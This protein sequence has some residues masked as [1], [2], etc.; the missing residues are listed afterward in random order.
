MDILPL[1]KVLATL[2]NK[3]EIN[4]TISSQKFIWLAIFYIKGKTILKGEKSR[5]KEKNK[6]PSFEKVSYKVDQK[7]YN[8][9]SGEGYGSKRKRQ[10]QGT[11]DNGNNH[12]QVYNVV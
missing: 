5:Q 1:A 3:V 10:N 7:T 2:K 8:A 9:V 4:D 11:E 12:C 6:Q